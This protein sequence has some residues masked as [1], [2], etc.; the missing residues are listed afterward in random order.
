MGGT[1]NACPVD[2]M[3]HCMVPIKPA[4]MAFDITKIASGGLALQNLGIGIVIILIWC[5]ADYPGKEKI[6]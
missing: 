1:S 6:W 3:E 2:R 5:E 4:L